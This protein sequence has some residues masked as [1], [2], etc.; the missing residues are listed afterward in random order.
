MELEA[1]LTLAYVNGHEFTIKRTLNNKG[2]HGWVERR[3]PL[4]F[5]KHIT[6]CLQF[7]KDQEDNP[8]GYWKNFVAR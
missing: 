6:A 2:V 1:S 3:K 7:A 4:L 8:D 5:K